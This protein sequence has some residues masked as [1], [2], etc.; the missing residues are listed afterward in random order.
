MGE[1]PEELRLKASGLLDATFCGNSVSKG[2][3]L[4]D[5]KLCAWYLETAD[6]LYGKPLRKLYNGDSGPRR[7]NSKKHVSILL[8]NEDGSTDREVVYPT[9][10]NHEMSDVDASTWFT[11]A[12][13]VFEKLVEM[14]N[15]YC[16]DGGDSSRRPR[17]IIWLMRRFHP[18]T[19]IVF[20]ADIRENSPWW[21]ELRGLSITDHVW[22]PL[23]LDWNDI[24][25]GLDHICTKQAKWFD[26]GLSFEQCFG[27]T[28]CL[29]PFATQDEIFYLIRI[30][31][32]VMVVYAE[33]PR[34]VRAA[35]MESLVDRTL[36]CMADFPGCI[37]EY[38]LGLRSVPSID[39]VRKELD[40]SKASN[41]RA[42]PP[43]I[44]KKDT[45]RQRLA[46]GSD[47]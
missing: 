47:A 27:A 37:R 23:P 20:M 24:T 32:L 35:K 38:Y 30:T 34:V 22:K 7:M 4:Q 21:S 13:E 12:P 45:K 18:S 11:K 26:K 39:D 28:G 19:V 44:D 40:A 25:D 8:K 46:P 31:V 3:D 10:I 36:P 43:T 2:L 15:H 41:K 9:R 1:M 16:Y 42:A 29:P 6:P 14:A 5:A 33:I 17:Q